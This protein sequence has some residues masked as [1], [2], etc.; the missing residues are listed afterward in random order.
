ML[1][2]SGI[3]L[4]KYYL[5]IDKAEQKQR[6]KAR[7]HDPLKQ[8]KVSPIDEKAVKLWKAYSR[9]RNAML[10]RTHTEFAPWIIVKANDKR[11]ARLNLIR[12]LL[13]RLHY[14]DK[15]ER[16]LAVDPAVAFAHDVDGTQAL[17]R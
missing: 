13:S 5:D 16:I 10:V 3:K 1:V 15:N 12:D 14:A 17:A 2:R 11:A 6:L 7:R 8:W 4:L 9:A